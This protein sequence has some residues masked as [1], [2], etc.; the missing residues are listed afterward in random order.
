MV[1]RYASIS[2]VRAVANSAL[3]QGFS[4]HLLSLLAFIKR[5]A[6]LVSATAARLAPPFLEEPAG[7]PAIRLGTDV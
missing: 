7:C 3:R 4:W 6:G 2:S 5:T 1:T